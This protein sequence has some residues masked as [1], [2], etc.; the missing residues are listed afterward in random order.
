MMR[1]RRR[2]LAI[3]GA[4]V[5]M[6]FVFLL[7]G[8]GIIM[9]YD[10]PDTEEPVELLWWSRHM[11]WNYDVERQCGI[12]TCRVTNKRNLLK[13]SRVCVETF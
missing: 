4:V 8:S 10:T 7:M 5:V 13:T 1:L 2:F 11:S 12:Y 6:W 9:D 3:V